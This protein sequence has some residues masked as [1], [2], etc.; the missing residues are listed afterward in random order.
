MQPV[1]TPFLNRE[2]S[3]HSLKP[4]RKEITLRS[5]I[6]WWYHLT[7]PAEPSPDAPLRVR[8]VFRHGRLASTIVFFVV[9]IELAVI[10]ISI[11]A[12]SPALLLNVV[13]S[14]ITTAVALWF[15]RKG[16]VVPAGLLIIIGNSLGVFTIPF[17]TSVGMGVQDLPIISILALSELV[18]VSLFPPKTV[19]LS[20]LLNC[21]LIW[22][23]LTLA[24]HSAALTQLLVVSKYDVMMQLVVLQFIVAGVV[25]LWVHSATKAIARADHAE[26]IAALQRD[27]A[28]QN[29]VIIEQKHQLDKAIQQIV[30]THMEVANGNFNARVSRTSDNV[31]WPIAG[32]L[33]NLLSRVQHW[34]HETDEFQRTQQAI[35][36][37]TQ[38]MAHAQQYDHFSRLER[39]GT[40]LDPLILELNSQR[41]E[42]DSAERS[43]VM[44][45]R[46]SFTVR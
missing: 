22:A 4:Y 16:N 3:Q 35:L 13:E 40:I 18:T 29:H 20:F 39:T 2:R 10:P 21:V 37:L 42:T 9:V 11:I 33:N 31:L 32:A 43:K 19:F 46:S 36:W 8:E 34:R 6:D 12:A 44:N 25:Y 41:V 26:V 45:K 24:P 38:S 7:S 15:N 14:L 30:R 17:R 1:Q 5:I 23:M 28:R 27:V